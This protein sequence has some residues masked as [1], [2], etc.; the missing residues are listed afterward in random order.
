MAGAAVVTGGAGAPVTGGLGVT[1]S[2][3]GALAIEGV[4]VAGEE[5]RA[6]GFAL[7]LG[8]AGVPA[9]A[10]TDVVAG[11]SPEVTDNGS[12]ASPTRVAAS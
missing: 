4:E 2:G 7:G 11:A 5:W 9:C 8:V 3:V 12:P 1:G 10:G 6:C